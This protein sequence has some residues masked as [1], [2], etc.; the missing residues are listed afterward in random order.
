MTNLAAQIA[1]TGA[2]AVHPDKRSRKQHIQI[3]TSYKR[4]GNAQALTRYWLD[5]CPRISRKVIDSL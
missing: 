5:Y 2:L 3:L 1:N 4:A